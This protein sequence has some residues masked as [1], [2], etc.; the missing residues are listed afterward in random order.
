MM[1]F[2]GLGFLVMIVVFRLGFH[3]LVVVVFRPGFFFF[4]VMIVFSFPAFLL[5]VIIIP[6]FRLFALIMMIAF[7]L[8]LSAVII[9]VPFPQAAFPELQQLQSFQFS[10]GDDVRP[11][12]QN[13]ER[14]LEARGEHIAHPENHAR[15]LEF[16]GVGGL[17]G[18]RVRRGDAFYQKVG[19]P[20]PLHDAGYQRMKRLDGG[21]HPG[22]GRCGSRKAR[23]QNYYNKPDE[24]HMLHE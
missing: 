10:Q 12:R 14:P 1:L 22:R 17:E 11:F 19:L 21:H 18:K 15:P 2:F 16:T 9:V 3:F 23:C 13:F 7:G 20:D 5:V 4:V 24:Q 6:G 8:F